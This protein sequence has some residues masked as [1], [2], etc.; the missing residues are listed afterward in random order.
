MTLMVRS[1]LIKAHFH[2]GVTVDS[3]REQPTTP[4]TMQACPEISEPSSNSRGSKEGLL[5]EPKPTS[6][7]SATR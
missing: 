5:H 7:V 3:D 4:A 2:H 6:L 1:R